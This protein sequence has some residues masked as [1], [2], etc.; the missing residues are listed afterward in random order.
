ML[1]PQTTSE[2]AECLA[3]SA[4]KKQTIQLGGN[5][6]K[7][8][9]GGPLPSPKSE[10]PVT[11]V[12]T[13]KLN[14]ILQYDPR[15]LTLS[16]EAGLPW[17]DL[18]RA[19]GEQRQ[20]VPLDPP[21]ANQATVGGV[22]ATNASS[23]RRRLYGTARDLIIG[24]QFATMA[25]KVVQSGGLVVKNVAGLDTGKLHIGAYGTLG[26][27]AVINFKVLPMP[28]ETRTFVLECAKASEAIAARDALLEGI[29]Q[30]LAVDLLSPKAAAACGLSAAWCLLVEAGGNTT[31]LDRYQRVLAAYRVIE[32]GAIWPR[33]TAFA[34][35]FLAANPN[36]AVARISTVLRQMGD[37]IER[38][39]AAH[40]VIA[41]GANGVSYVY[42]ASWPVPLD[43]KGAAEY[44]PEGRGREG[45]WWSPPA[46]LELMKRVK[47]MMDPAG[48]LNPGR[49]YGLI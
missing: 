5:F 32:G 40:P 9:A 26:A 7:N 24:M 35:S 22:I 11:L 28:V 10:T 41:R 8:R 36:G 15:D 6:S 42:C 31:L 19:L 1:E 38:Y 3:D 12:S 17:R 13:R 48:V 4:A 2:L 30:P 45:L 33:V 14:R 29:L 37:V 18:V 34:E 49:L 39:G 46:E 21:F 25:G 23:P 47:G 27:M 44:G 43:G 20:M 16:V